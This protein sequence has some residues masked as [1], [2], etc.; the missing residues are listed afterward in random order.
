MP[1]DKKHD[2]L[3]RSLDADLPDEDREAL[4]AW[5]SESP[6]ARTSM[7][8]HQAV[9][10]AVAEQGPSSFCDGFA[11]RVMTALPNS[12]FDSSVPQHADRNT[13]PPARRSRQTSAWRRTAAGL[14]MLVILAIAIL[15]VRPW[16]TTV[17]VPPGPPEQVTL[18][19]GTTVEMSGGSSLHYTDSWFHRERHATLHGE[20]FFDVAT[21]DRP[22]RVETHN[23]QIRVQGTTFN[24]RAWPE[25]M[26][27]ETR[28]SLQTGQ[29][30]VQSLSESA[31]AHVLSPGETTVTHGDSTRS[32]SAEIDQVTAWRSGGLAFV[33]QSLKSVAQ[34]LYHRFGVE[35]EIEDPTLGERTLTYLNPDPESPGSVIDDICHTLDLQYHR[36]AQ[37]YR[38]HP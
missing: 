17:E 30:E 24:V 10:D 20:A 25:A 5:L 33:D 29:V 15:F 37:G 38:I 7:A 2:L 27:N 16:T 36:T 14:V 22:F 4:D 18:S 12:A 19:D 1:T 34:A 11:D 26:D 32:V 21:N 28:V 35:V 13:R 8:E 31:V 9:A 23:A 3:I 6:E